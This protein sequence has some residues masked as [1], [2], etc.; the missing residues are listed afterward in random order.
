MTTD[1]FKKIRPGQRLPGIPS[2]PWNA[3]LDLVR[4]RGGSALSG[5]DPR[6]GNDSSVVRI[7][8]TTGSDLNAHEAVGYS[9]P[10]FDVTTDPNQFKH[11]RPA[12]LVGEVL[13][14]EF[15]I[16]RWAVTI[17]PIAS[18]MVGRAVVAGLAIA[19]INVVDAGHDRVDIAAANPVPQ[20]APLG[21][22]SIVW[23]ESGVGTKWAVLMLRAGPLSPRRATI[24]SSTL[25]TPNIWSY[26]VTGF[27]KSGSGH[28][29]FILG[30]GWLAT[31]LN[32]A[33]K[34]NTASGVTGTGLD[35]STFP[36]SLLPVP[37]GR[38]VEIWAEP[39]PG[40]A[41]EYWFDTDNPVECDS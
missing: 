9:Q 16:E 1:P 37:N 29:G 39:V 5:A 34:G 4:E 32:I 15:H 28:S 26:E 12:P 24:N 38:V 7:H 41:T 14:P 22:A 11:N 3:M 25:L 31:A 19:Q 21:A 30:G 40:A 18:N 35:L 20:S 36:G 23:K 8:N 6:L 33:E 13:A 17:E 10:L 27:A 2:A